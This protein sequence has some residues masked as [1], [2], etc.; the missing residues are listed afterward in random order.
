MASLAVRNNNPGNLKDPAT[1]GFRV[2]PDMQS[3]LKGLEQDLNAKITG[4][5]RTGLGPHSTLSQ[6]AA[7]YAPASDNNDPVG[8]A[9]KL[10][11]RL[12][13]SP[14]TPLSALQPRVSEFAH[15]VAQNEDADAA[16][17]LKN[18]GSQPLASAGIDT[19]AQKIK[20][21]YPQYQDI[22]DDQLTQ[23]ILAKY[24]QYS[25]M[26]SGAPSGGGLTS[27]LPPAPV[28]PTTMPAPVDQQGGLAG[29]ILHGIG[30]FAK[31]ITA[32]V[33]TMLARP[34][35]AGAELLGASPE[36]VNAFSSKVPI[37]GENGALD[38]PQ[39]GADV[40][41]D[42]GRGLETAALGL[43]PVAGGAAFGAGNSLEQ[44]NNVLSGQTIGQTATG[45]AGGKL[46]DLAA[47]FLAKGAGVLVPKFAKELGG[48]VGEATAPAVK[49]V[50]DFAEKT[51]ILPK[52][53]SNAVNTVAGKV[54]AAPGAVGKTVANQY[55]LGTGQTRKEALDAV[56]KAL[57]ETGKKSAGVFAKADES[58]LRGLE[59]MATNAE[60]VK[61]ADGEVYNPTT[62]NLH[63]HVEALNK[64]KQDAYNTW[65]KEVQGATGAGVKVDTEPIALSL[66][67]MASKP[68]NVRLAAQ[69][70][71]V[72]NEI[73]SLQG[74]PEELQAYLQ[75]LNSGL[76]GVFSG[77]EASA[78][79]DVDAQ[80]VH[81]LND[82]LDNSV[83]DIGTDS[84]PIR[85][86]KD[87]Y[88]SYKAVEDGLVKKAQQAARR[89]DGGMGGGLYDYINPFNIADAFDAFTHPVGAL[90]AGARILLG[91]KARAAKDPE[92]I[93]QGIFQTINTYK[94][95]GG[96]PA[97]QLGVLQALRNATVGGGVKSAFPQG[98]ILNELM[99]GNP[100]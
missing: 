88:S 26:V 46:L 20:Q 64:L 87:L 49:A 58:K 77:G 24:P 84:K 30:D 85:E 89:P 11:T 33:A 74:S 39:S 9:S 93:L 31:G 98:G 19:F 55:G 47:P 67:E 70:R 41:K 95:I 34:L 92:K 10:A 2:F 27:P 82:A 71:K 1:G 14:E 69:A 56:S 48:K 86:A 8:Y 68:G 37:Y 16:G 45:A 28:A 23:K 65:M 63:Q 36:Q 94:G 53:L 62:A 72:A 83:V 76:K 73:R 12:G 22:P 52:P 99:S 40:K 44:G 25:D 59:N 5:T 75:T 50:G 61:L 4:N 66:E 97:S 15:A 100:R 51:Q 13:V 6:F 60:K 80:A 32:P 78:A 79:R 54:S 57:G 29:S 17:M 35:Q 43:G 91:N 90:K 81:L 21:K 38:V 42:F 96:Q 3:G 7:V 18:P